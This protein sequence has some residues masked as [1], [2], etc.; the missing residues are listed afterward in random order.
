MIEFKEINI[1]SE[2][3]LALNITPAQ[4]K[5]VLDLTADGCTIPFIARY[6]KEATNFLN[7][8]QI[9]EII[10]F[11]E[12]L[13]ALD[14]RKRAVLKSLSETGNYTDK[15]ALLVVNADSMTTLEEIYAPFK[16]NRKTKADKALSAGFLPFA[17]YII[18]KN[19]PFG[20]I[21]EEAAK[22]VCDSFP[23]ADSVLDGTK[24]I[25]A[26]KIA[27]NTDIRQL[28][29]KSLENGKVVS[30]VKRGKSE[31]GTV[32]SDYFD[33]CEN[34]QKIAPHR[35]MAINR[36]ENEGF[37]K[38]SIQPDKSG[39]DLKNT[40]TR[41]FF[42]KHSEFFDECSVHSLQSLILPEIEKEALNK[43]KE[44]AV[45][46][47]VEIFHQNLEQILLFPPF[48]EKPVIGID[49]GI[50]T[51][52][53]AVLLDKHGSFIDSVLLNLHTNSEEALKLK[54]WIEDYGVKGI[55]IGSGT[56]GRT[57]FEIMQKYFG[58][59]LTIA[60][61]S[62]DGASIYSASEVAREEFPDLDIT[63]RGAISIGRRFQDPMSELVKI[64]PESLGIGQY[65][66]DIPIKKLSEKLKRTVEWAV[67]KVGANLNT[68]SPYLLAYISGLDRK[69]SL[70]IVNFRNSIKR[71][72]NIEE[73]KK[74]KGI[75][76]KSFE[77][78]AGF[79][80]IFD[81]DEFLDSTGVHPENYELV[82]NTAKKLKIKLENSTK[83]PK[84]WEENQDFLQL[85]PKTVAEELTKSK[86]DCRET[87][88]SADFSSEIK[89]IEDLKEGMIVNGIV[90]NIAAFG[91]FV[92]I[93]IKEKG[94]LHISEISLL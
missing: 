41:L 52:C 42:N 80:R 34:L 50:R 19:P 25:I 58:N 4:V 57:A 35:V 77:Q 8:I 72:R 48:G 27:D 10:D 43:I 18:D 47:S 67:N 70:E 11:S 22:L 16:P 91:A 76:E 1:V 60:S 61:V 7:E 37:L 64:S 3:S 69:K 32:Y 92:E 73:L 38:I 14:K 68:A 39:D 26:Q 20:K 79:L 23:D 55:A 33:F 83:N 30:K 90:N 40:I 29:R 54:K 12:K 46:S 85:L 82:K 65:Q 87:Y 24:E 59:S 53:K 88:E 2:V 44:A 5:A 75:G 51:G 94:L 56:F 13:S 93:G 63:V 15:L 28:V 84:F 36:G 6:R 89:S 17:E 21:F 71:F 31:S 81:G 45:E 66:H 86:L 9:A 49:P 78:C 74:I 62:E